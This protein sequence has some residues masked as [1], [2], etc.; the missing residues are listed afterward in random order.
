M[1]C[2]LAE[3][4]A[5]AGHRVTVLTGWPNHPKG[6]LYKGWKVRFRH[7]S[8]DPKGYRIVRCGHAMVPRG[9]MSGRMWYYLTFGLS[10]LI[11]GLMIKRIDTVYNDSTPLFGTWLG[12]LLAKAKCARVVY[13]IMDLYPESAGNAGMM[14]EG[15]VYRML[16]WADTR[17]CKRSD[18]IAT[19]SEGLKR[20]IAKRGIDPKRIK[21]IPF[22]VDPDKIRPCNRENPWRRA[23]GI[24]TDKFVVLYA[25][26]IGYIS[27]AE[28]LVNAA[29]RLQVCDDILILVVG[30]GVAKAQME[31][32]ARDAGLS[33]MRFLPFQSAEVLSDMQATAD[34]GLVTL[35]PKA[36]ETSFPSK[37]LGYMAA[38]RAVIAS[39][40]ETADT[41]SLIRNGGFGVVTP[42]QDPQTL[43]DAI[44]TLADDRKR[45]EALGAKARAYLLKHLSRQIVVEKYKKVILGDQCSL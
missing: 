8:W 22:W 33:N 10:A 39:C 7:V 3:D 37:V 5:A 40:S 43:A 13:S 2:E 6:I 11:N 31:K 16:R 28:V 44:R 32:Q 29:R 34:V 45:C 24:P 35:L 41:A 17:L 26:T 30:E 12:W 38:G 21:V 36:G 14:R 1:H 4:L 20:G 25:G 19:L 9:R 15:L 18:A 42:T 23:H 27:G